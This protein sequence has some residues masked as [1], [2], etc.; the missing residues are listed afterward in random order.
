MTTISGSVPALEPAPTATAART[1]T[2]SGTAEARPAAPQ[3]P[4]AQR[5]LPVVGAVYVLA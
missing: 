4:W 3:R 2:I 5:A 1:G